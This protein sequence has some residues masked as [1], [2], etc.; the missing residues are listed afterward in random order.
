M[1]FMIGLVLISSCT[2]LSSVEEDLRDALDQTLH[3][4]FFETVQQE[5]T[6]LSFEEFRQQFKFISVVYL[7]DGCQPCYPKFIE[8]HH[9]MD[10]LA[11]RDDYTVLFIISGD[12]YGDFMA[13]VFDQEFIDTPYYVIMDRDYRFMNKNM[14]IPKWIFDSSVLIDQ[15][16]KIKLI[17][18][19]YSTPQ[20]TELFYDVCGKWASKKGDQLNTMPSDFDWWLKKQFW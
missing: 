16:N 6:L 14:E 10:S 12:N 7:Q 11:T 20:M 9:K 5:N 2:R 4:K 18:A 8:W 13:K 15:E 19:P 3:L 17:G 1:L